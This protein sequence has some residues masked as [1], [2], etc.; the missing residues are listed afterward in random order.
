MSLAAF[1]LAALGLVLSVASL[2]WQAATFVLSGSR[3]KAELRHGA[4]GPGGH[5]GLVS[6]KPGLQTLASLAPQGWTEEVLGVEVR[7]VG[8][9]AVTVT[10]VA[11]VHAEKGIKYRPVGA[12]IGEELPFRLEAQSSQS[13][14]M[15]A[16]DVHQM[17][18]VA[19]ET[20]G[21]GDPA[22]LYVEVELGTGKVCKTREKLA[23]SGRG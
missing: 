13:W 10:S 20:L 9:L 4:R 14:F 3:V 7:N 12:L 5:G 22:D 15:S 18:A 8:R 1:I 2:S 16:A 19:A 11:V 23:L 21:A 17:I 6:G